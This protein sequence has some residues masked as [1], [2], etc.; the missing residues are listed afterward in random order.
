MRLFLAAPQQLEEERKVVHNTVERLNQ[1]IQAAGVS[2]RPLELLDW[3]PGGPDTPPPQPAQG[4]A[5]LGLAW[6]QLDPS[7]QEASATEETFLD[8]MQ[9]WGEGSSSHGYLYRCMR[10]PTS[11]HD[12]DGKAFDAVSRVFDS[13]RKGDEN[14]GIKY[15]EYF[16]A[17]GLQEHLERDLSELV[18]ALAQEKPAPQEPRPRGKGR[19][20]EYRLRAGEAYEVTYLAVAMANGKELAQ[21]HASRH[22]D[23]EALSRSFRSLVTET[24]ASYGGEA[25]TWSDFGGLLLFWRKRSQ[26]H[27]IMTGLKVLHN[28]PVFN[29]DLEQNPL[30]EPV[31][32]R[33]AAHDA[34]IVF[35]LPI[36]DIVS[37]EMDFVTGLENGYTAPGELTISKRLLGKVDPRLAPRFSFKGRFEDEPIYGCRLPSTD[38]PPQQAN[39][40][41]LSARVEHEISMASSL[42]DAFAS[43][44]DATGLDSISAAVD[45]A[46]SGLNRFALRFS[47][48]D[49]SW[50]TD[51]SRASPSTQPSSEGR[52]QRCGESSA[53]ASPSTRR[54]PGVPG[55]S[56]P[57]SR[58]RRADG[59]DRW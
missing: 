28:L 23:L 33:A 5:F 16:S 36:T 46:Y 56:K 20:F 18:R 54:P 41:E 1:K 10:L 29:L 13:V 44:P 39:L 14:T 47:Q 11:L 38:Q 7:D 30:S 49:Q 27:A 50:S 58:Q 34:V 24:A 21:R 32:I 48:L 2:S 42:L 53:S 25:F 6:L 31:Q 40:D 3:T 12:I 22:E 4:D 52:R 45:E 57:H 9:K 59:P 26:D 19:E 17:S 15:R 51:F 43:A 35:R 8:A 37:Q 55:N